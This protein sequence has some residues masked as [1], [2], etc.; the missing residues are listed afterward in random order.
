MLRPASL[1]LWN[2]YIYGELLI[3]FFCQKQGKSYNRCFVLQIKCT[4][5]FKCTSQNF[6]KEI[7]FT[8]N[9]KNTGNVQW[10][11][12]QSVCS[13]KQQSKL[14]WKRTCRSL[15]SIN[16]QSWCD[17]YYFISVNLAHLIYSY[18][19]INVTINITFVFDF[20]GLLPSLTSA[21]MG[22]IL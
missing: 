20:R 9:N 15:F 3:F 1:L 4:S 13:D 18:S 21:G 16:F 11:P 14:G 5:T 17:C 7:A 10:L 2:S 8:F 19:L 22:V 12:G 6:Q